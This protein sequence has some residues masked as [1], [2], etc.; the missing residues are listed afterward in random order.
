MDRKGSCSGG[1]GAFVPLVDCGVEVPVTGT[2]KVNADCFSRT[3][4]SCNVRRS[5]RRLSFSLI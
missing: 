4:S 1:E 3:F 2:W 5:W